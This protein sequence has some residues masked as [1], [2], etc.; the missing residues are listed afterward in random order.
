[1]ENTV[2]RLP[3]T[4]A[5]ERERVIIYL[6]E[7]KSQLLSGHPNSHMNHIHLLSY[8]YARA[9]IFKTVHLT[10]FTNLHI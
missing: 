9:K 4:V 10:E 7:K 8:G 1:M 2:P 6:K 3:Q 5:S